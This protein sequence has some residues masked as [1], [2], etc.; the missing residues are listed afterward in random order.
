MK[1][2]CDIP[3]RPSAVE[4]NECVKE[5]LAAYAH[6]AWSGWMQYLFSKSTECADG[7]A[8]IPAWAVSRWKRQMITPYPS[9]PPDEQESD[10]AEA[11]KILAICRKGG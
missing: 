11:D 4:E 8:S 2:L 5:Q 1:T 7:S 3:A 10:R 9:L 6:Q